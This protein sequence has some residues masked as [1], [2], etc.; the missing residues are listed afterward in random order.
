MR[1]KHEI[2]GNNQNPLYKT[3]IY[4][5]NRIGNDLGNFGDISQRKKL[6]E[7]LE[8]KSFKWYLDTV[9]P[10]LFIPGDAVASGEIRNLWSGH[11]NQMCV[12]S[13]SKKNNL[14]KPVGLYPCHNQVCNFLKMYI[15]TPLKTSIHLECIPFL[16]SGR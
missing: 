12:D 13:A 10:E 14:H 6:R 2:K 11:G 8:C 16:F 1:K 5:F 3:L 4:V 9:Y 15:V 7:D